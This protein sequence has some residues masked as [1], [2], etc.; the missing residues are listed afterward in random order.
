MIVRD[1][2]FKP[3]LYNSSVWDYWKQGYISD[4]KEVLLNIRIIGTQEQIEIKCVEYIKR[5]K[6][7]LD[8]I[9]DFKVHQPTDYWYGIFGEDA[10]K[11]NV[12]TRKKIKEYKKMYKENNNQAIII[13]I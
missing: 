12:K 4:L 7:Q 10:E 13:R 11:E 8:E 1:F 6:L 9:Y 3:T 2:H 5:N